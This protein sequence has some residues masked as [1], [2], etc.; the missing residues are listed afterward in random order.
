MIV[1]DFFGIS[2]DCKRSTSH[3]MI[4]HLRNL[5]MVCRDMKSKKGTT[6]IFY[7]VSLIFNSKENQHQF[8]HISLALQWEKTSRQPHYLQEFLSFRVMS[9]HSC[10]IS[11]VLMLRKTSVF[12]FFFREKNIYIWFWPLQ[13]S[14]MM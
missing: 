2:L 12:L 10:P 9:L 8:I 11:M 14:Q 3:S 6:L 4:S 5:T 13:L 1:W 7:V